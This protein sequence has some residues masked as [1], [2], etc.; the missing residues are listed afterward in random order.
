MHEAMADSAGGPGDTLASS[1]PEEPTFLLTQPAGASP[2]RRAALVLGLSLV[3]FFAALPVSRWPLPRAPAFI[4]M[5]ESALVINDSITALLLFGQFRILRLHALLPLACAYLFTALLAGLHALTFPGAFAPAGLLGAGPQTTASLYVFWHGGFP[6]FVLAYALLGRSAGAS[7]PRLAAYAWPAAT[8]CLAVALAAWATLGQ[9]SLPIML[10]S[11]HYAPALIGSTAVISVLCL[12]A[13]V[14]LWGRRPHTVLDLWVSVALIAWTFDVS[15]SALFNAARFDLG[16]YAGRAY[17]LLASS[18]VL[19]ELLLENGL[20]YSRL[21]R[22]HE[23]ER[24]QAE[25]LREARDQ[26]RSADAAKSMFLASMSHEIRT[27]MNAVIGLTG[28][29]LGTPLD[30]TQR[31]YLEKVQASSKALLGLL[32]DILDYSKI[33][34]GKIELE[35][36]PFSP[37]EIVENVANLFS[38]KLDESGLDL[39]IEIEREVPARVIGD[40][41]RLA[42]VL[43]NLVGNAIKFTVAGEIVIGVHRG[44]AETPGEILLRFSV[45]DTGIGLT[46]EQ[47][48]RLFNVFQQADQSTARKYGGTGLGLAICKQLVLL[49]GGDIQVQPA[50]GG[51]SEFSFTARFAAAEGPALRMDPLRLRGMRTLVLD[52]QPTERLI[53]QQMLQSWRFQVATAA[54]PDD[55]LHKLRRADPSAPHELLIMEWKNGGHELLDQARALVRERSGTQL[56]A[57]VMT[58]LSTRERVARALGGVAGVALVVKPLTPSRLFEAVLRLQHGE[59]APA[60]SVVPGHVDLAVALASIRGASVLLVEDNL[61][62]QQ[63]AVGLLTTGGLSVTVAGD[64]MEGVEAVKS[65]RFDIVLMDLQMPQM[66]G[67]QATRL[68]RQLPDREGLPIIAMTAAA[69]EQDRQECLA[70]GMNAHVTKPIEPAE[71]VR[72]LLRWIPAASAG[73]VRPS[74]SA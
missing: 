58:T 40:S 6:V 21:A 42:Q 36:E 14:V 50:P 74:G 13:A 29:V 44:A 73:S 10:D 8:V 56:E 18:L 43:N 60:S 25:D 15:L 69:R 32:N 3:A 37:E 35:S 16:F 46:P 71:L 66:D 17:G 54:F 57:I 45:R 47:A 72:A 28:L 1:P 12:V 20:L 62:N 41:L 39:V 64:G 34:A 51:G 4:P 53:L 19:A 26:A 70:A 59:Q 68:I 23:N 38:A 11:G 24:R 2:R 7:A 65:G 61:V 48:A 5:Y 9:Q 63:V 52:A 30:A 49:M 67:P 22:L 27:P 31:D 33:E 55:A